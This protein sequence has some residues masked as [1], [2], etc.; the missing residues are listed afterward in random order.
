MVVLLEFLLFFSSWF[1][2]FHTGGIL[3]CPEVLGY[4]F[5]SGRCAKSVVS[6]SE[7][8]VWLL[9]GQLPWKE[10]RQQATFFSGEISK[11]K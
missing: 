6:N 7:C 5:P 11:H 10:M 4:L 2:L 1:G 8:M 9:T 3:E